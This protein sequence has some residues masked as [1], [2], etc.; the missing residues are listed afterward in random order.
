MN[1]ANPELQI[2][3][4][5]V[6]GFLTS[7]RQED[8]VQVQ[9]IIQEIQ[10]PDFFARDRIMIAGRHSVTTMVVSKI[11][12]IDLTG[13]GG[14]VWKSPPKFASGLRDVVEMPEQEFLYQV[15]ARDL[16]HMERRRPSHKPGQTHLGFVDVHLAGGHH[17]YLQVA[18][19]ALLPAERLQRVHCLLTLLGLPF[20]L[21]DG[22][23]G[24]ANLTTA[25]KFTGH[26][27]PPEVPADVWSAEEDES[28]NR[29]A[30]AR[31][32]L[33]QRNGVET[34]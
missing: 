23:V 28:P 2:R 30:S 4:Y 26:P 8:P 17:L 11:A 18:L 6:D 9:R 27:G 21:P 5:T 16:N 19:A 22:G 14:P 33:K 34:S 7:F 12:R 10:R 29:E 32:L 3:I 25:V 24:I 20:R 13:E 1:L 31:N 15:E